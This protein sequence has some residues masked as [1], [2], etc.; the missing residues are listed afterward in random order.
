MA[1]TTKVFTSEVPAFV[2]VTHSPFRFDRHPDDVETLSRHGLSS[3]G[4]TAIGVTQEEG[5]PALVVN[6]LGYT[7]GIVLT[8]DNA[9]RLAREVARSTSVGGSGRSGA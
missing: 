4:T 8:S 6:F 5:Q 2:E 3:A 1:E 9:A 7:I